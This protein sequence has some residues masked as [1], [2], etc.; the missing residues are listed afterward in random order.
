MKHDQIDYHQF[1]ELSYQL[2][3]KLKKKSEKYQGILCPLRG[4]FFLSYFMSNHLKLPIQYLEISSYDGKTQKEFKIK[5]KTKLK[6][7][8]YLLCDDIYDTGK[9]IKKIKEIFPDCD[10]DSV[11][12]VSKQNRDDILFAQKAEKKVWV[13]F[14]WETM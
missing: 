4:G 11:F 8:K 14:F 2:L 3:E 9:T 12:L 7:G 10:F 5:N 1:L 13:D 6:K